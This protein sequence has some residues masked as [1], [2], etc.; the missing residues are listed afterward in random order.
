MHLQKIKHAL[1]GIGIEQFWGLRPIR[2]MITLT[3]LLVVTLLAQAQEKHTI[4]GTI[5]DGANGETMVG[6]NVFLEP[7]TKGTTTNVYGFYSITVP[8]GKY[9]LKVSFL[10]YETF[11]KEINLSK[12]IE[13]NMELNE[14]SF[15]K[16][17]VVVKGEKTDQNTKSSKMSAVEVPT[18]A[19]KSTRRTSSLKNRYSS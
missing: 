5:T 6:T 4:S 16:E 2:S 19:V 8:D 15:S 14:S 18:E 17:E 7:I 10:G 13:L 11:S 3:F 9:T 12:N 1:Q